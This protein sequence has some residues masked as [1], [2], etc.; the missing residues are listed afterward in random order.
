MKTSYQRRKDE[1]LKLK[2]EIHELKIIE[3]AFIS[4]IRGDLMGQEQMKK[5]S[6]NCL[7]RHTTRNDLEEILNYKKA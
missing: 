6:I 7:K 1:I 5:E 3:K 2:E 4:Y